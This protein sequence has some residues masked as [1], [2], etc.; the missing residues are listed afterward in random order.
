MEKYLRV[1]LE[2]KETTVVFKIRGNIRH[3][4]YLLRQAFSASVLAENDYKEL[5]NNW[6]VKEQTDNIVCTKKIQLDTDVEFESFSEQVQD[7]GVPFPSITRIEEVIGVCLENKNK[8]LLFPNYHPD[9]H[10]LAVLERWGEVS[11]IIFYYTDNKLTAR[12]K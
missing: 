5:K 10:E 12:P 9:S 4:A 8:A 1:L 11:G 2:T 3:T 7:I 6:T